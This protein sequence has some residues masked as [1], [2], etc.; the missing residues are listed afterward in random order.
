MGGQDVAETLYA[1]ALRAYN[2]IVGL[3]LGDVAVRIAAPDPHLQAAIRQLDGI[4]PRGPH[5]P[6][7][8]RLRQHRHLTAAR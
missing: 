4:P 3:E 8:L 2:Q 1:T 5:P 6:P 7:G